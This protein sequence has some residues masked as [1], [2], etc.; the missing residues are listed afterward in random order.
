V[1]L[2]SRILRAGGVAASP[3]TTGDGQLNAPG[4]GPAVPRTTPGEH[5]R[6]DPSDGRA[7]SA[8]PGRLS[9]SSASRRPGD[10]E[11]QE[12]P[13][14]GRIN[15]DHPLACLHCEQRLNAPAHLQGRKAEEL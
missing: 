14:C 13:T 3:K 7:V 11:P 9:L 6:H 12:C 2:L 4:N 1:G 15:L 8:D 10:L 5:E